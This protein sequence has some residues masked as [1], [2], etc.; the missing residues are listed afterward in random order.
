MNPHHAFR[1]AVEAGD[2]RA[3]T[4]TFHPDATLHS[5]AVFEPYAG[6]ETIG[7][8]LGVLLD[9]F[10]D[11]HYTDEFESPDGARALL[12]RA[13]V[14]DRE[15]QGLDVLRFDEA[16][17]ITDLTVMIRPHTG[18]EALMQAVAPRLAAA[19]HPS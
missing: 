17:R 8:L 2:A 9:V 16:G 11:F 15:L 3:V 10:E 12:F 18:L 19:R 7:L 5:P 14:G 4:A 6:R 1:A 13:R